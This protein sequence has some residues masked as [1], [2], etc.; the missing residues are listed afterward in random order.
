MNDLAPVL[1]AFLAGDPS[2]TDVD[3]AYQHLEQGR[4]KEAMAI[5]SV[6]FY[7]DVDRVRAA[8]GAARACLE[9]RAPHEALVWARWL[10]DSNDELGRMLMAVAF[11][12]LADYEGVAAVG[13]ECDPAVLAQVGM[14]VEYGLL[15]HAVSKQGRGDLVG[16]ESTLL[17]ALRANGRDPSLW[18]VLGRVVEAQGVVHAAVLDAVRQ[19]ETLS[20]L[21]WL[22]QG[23]AIGGEAVLEAMWSAQPGDRV[24]LGAAAQIVPQAPLDRAMVWS[25]RVRTIGLESICPLRAKAESAAFPAVE[26]V[27][28]AVV[29]SAAYEDADA[30][31]LIRCACSGLGVDD[32]VT[33]LTIVADMAPDALEEA[34]NGVAHDVPHALIA[35]RFLYD[36]G[37]VDGALAVT[38]HALQ[39]ADADP[40]WTPA[41]TTSA[42]Q[43]VLGIPMAADLAAGFAAVDA[44]ELAARLEAACH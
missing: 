2:D 6:A 27:Q 16:A 41:K 29:V 22:G 17:E 12:Q 25:Q 8:A 20:A 15:V 23:S 5:L 30:G 11:C 40:V 34:I 3:L 37:A 24:V 21:A 10:R 43:S 1:V 4:P 13:D 14:P 19:G 9:L 18:A 42:L 31:E 32:V 35:A 7:E 28:A 26:R 39:L 36:G 38:A 33:G 44:G